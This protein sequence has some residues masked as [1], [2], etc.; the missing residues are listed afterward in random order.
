MEVAVHSLLEPWRAFLANYNFVAGTLKARGPAHHDGGTGDRPAELCLP[1]VVAL[2]DALRVAGYDSTA[3]GALARLALGYRVPRGDAAAA[4]GEENVD[5]LSASGIAEDMCETVRLRG[6]VLAAGPLLAY[7]PRDGARPDRVYLGADTAFLVDAADRLGRHARAGCAADL[8]TGT[9]VVAAAM[10]ARHRRVVA[11]DLTPR[12][13]RTASV[14]AALNRF[15]PGHRVHSCVADVAGG[16]RPGVFDMVAANTP[17]VPSGD[18]GSDRRIFADGGPTGFELPRRFITEGSALLRPGGVLVALAADLTFTGGRSPL[19]DQ[20]VLLER[21]G[22]ETTIVPTGHGRRGE[23]LERA[24][25]PRVR[26]TVAADHV[27]VVVARRPARCGLSTELAA[28]ADAWDGGAT[29]ARPG[30]DG[31]PR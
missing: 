14:T 22:C 30:Y 16:L 29:G 24:V 11:T 7:L 5:G 10:A 4:L 25:L 20:C 15:P 27:A 21:Q 31:V 8:G 19:R 17:W 6:A 9:G 26:G 2:G 13:A 1:A 23:A 3:G 12:A 28:M 18:M